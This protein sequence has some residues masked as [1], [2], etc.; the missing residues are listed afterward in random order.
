MADKIYDTWLE[1]KRRS[2]EKALAIVTDEIMGGWDVNKY[3]DM[4]EVDHFMLYRD[5]LR[6]F[7]Y[8]SDLLATKQSTFLHMNKHTIGA[9]IRQAKTVDGIDEQRKVIGNMLT[10]RINSLHGGL[11]KRG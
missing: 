9:L 11:T 10:D 3:W 4:F 5:A 2:D 8:P 7:C 6:R 1:D